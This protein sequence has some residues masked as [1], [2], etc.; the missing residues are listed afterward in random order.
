M[1]CRVVG[2]PRGRRA[3]QVRRLY[4]AFRRDGTK[5]LASRRRGRPSNRQLPTATRAQALTLVRERYADFG[6]TFA[7][8]DCTSR[9]CMSRTDSARS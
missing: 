3:R 9:P 8:T 5:A 7:A 6:P 2:L 4:R 1:R